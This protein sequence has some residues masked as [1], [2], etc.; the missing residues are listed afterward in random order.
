[1]M[2]SKASY[3]KKTVKSSNSKNTK[4]NTKVTK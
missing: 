2:P 3:N 1:M 4:K